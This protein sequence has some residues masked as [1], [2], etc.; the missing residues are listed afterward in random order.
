MLEVNKR[1][2]SLRISNNPIGDDGLSAISDNLH[3]NQILIHLDVSYCKFQSKGVRSV[4]K[5]LNVNKTLKF[6]NISNNPIGDHGIS[7]I[8]SG[9][10]TNTIAS[11][12]LIELDIHNCEI[13][14]ESVKSFADVLE[15]NE[16]LRSVIIS[17]NQDH[18]R[19]DE[20]IALVRGM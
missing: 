4:G 3:N 7:L 14:D 11:T 8:A 15:R 2:K 20:M 1:L 12:A 10:M 9:L 19:D 18:F 6:L 17:Q 16:T 13:H 5:M